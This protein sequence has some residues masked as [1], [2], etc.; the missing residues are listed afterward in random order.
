VNAKKDVKEIAAYRLPAAT[1]DSITWQIEV[2][3]ER[4]QPLQFGER[5]RGK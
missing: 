1:S 4:Q 3:K 2:V 5:L